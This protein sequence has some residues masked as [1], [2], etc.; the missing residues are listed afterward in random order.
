MQSPNVPG[1][2]LKQGPQTHSHPHHVGW[3]SPAYP[4]T[5]HPPLTPPHTRYGMQHFP[6]VGTQAGNFPP[7]HT[8]GVSHTSVSSVMQSNPVAASP[9]MPHDTTPNMHRPPASASPMEDSS[10]GSKLG[11]PRQQQQ[12]PIGGQLSVSS[13]VTTVPRKEPSYGEHQSPHH[14]TKEHSGRK[15]QQRSQNKKH[16]GVSGQGQQQPVAAE[17]QPAIAE[18]QLERQ[19]VVAE[20]QPLVDERQPTVVQKRLVNSGQ[21][22]PGNIESNARFGESKPGHVQQP[23]NRLEHQ[24][25]TSRGRGRGGKG[26]GQ[27]ERRGWS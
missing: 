8:H 4:K 2:L 16:P 14:S 10:Q 17:R 23:G 18:R 24:R 26:R 1:F 22:P 12:V 6:L 7:F 15:R 3:G 9:D 11:Q 25:H 21:R 13:A 5:G 27:R 19:A 20:R